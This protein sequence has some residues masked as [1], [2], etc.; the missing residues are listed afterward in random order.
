MTEPTK[1]HESIALIVESILKEFKRK[2]IPKNIANSACLNIVIWGFLSQGDSDEE[3]LKH[4]QFFTD[5]LYAIRDSLRENGV[6]L[7]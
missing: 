2:N 6:H 1:D 3:I 7:G 5:A 4:S